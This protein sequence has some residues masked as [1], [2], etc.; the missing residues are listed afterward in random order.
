MREQVIVIQSGGAG[1]P[2]NEVSCF[3]TMEEAERHVEGRLEAGS[4]QE[5][6]QVFRAVKL[7]MEVRQRPVVT[8][9][10][11]AETPSAGGTPPGVNAEPA[12]TDPDHGLPRDVF[13]DRSF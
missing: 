5:D 9:A 10:A 7:E 2:G 11:R 1:A 3:E 4:R 6:I 8:F 13:T 12:R